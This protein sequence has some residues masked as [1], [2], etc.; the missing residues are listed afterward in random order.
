M[1]VKFENRFFLPGSSDRPDVDDLE[2]LFDFALGELDEA[3][4]KKK[5]FLS[6]GPIG[7]LCDVARRSVREPGK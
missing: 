3:L 1:L 5:R 2:S 4:P 6:E 7:D